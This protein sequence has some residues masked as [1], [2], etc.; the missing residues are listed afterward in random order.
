M[1]T[2]T[3]TLYVIPTHQTENIMKHKHCLYIVV[4]LG[5]V[6]SSAKKRSYLSGICLDTG[7]RLAYLKYLQ[8]HMNRTHGGRPKYCCYVCSKGHSTKKA[9]QD[10]VRRTHEVPHILCEI[11]SASRK[12]SKSTTPS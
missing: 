5:P 10:H 4:C 7:S 12:P 8:N 6:N 1:Y 2:G 11:F 9:L 3:I